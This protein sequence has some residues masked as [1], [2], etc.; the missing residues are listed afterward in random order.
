[1]ILF[2]VLI[3]SVV[4]FYNLYLKE[5]SRTEIKKQ[6]STNKAEDNANQMEDNANQEVNNLI[7]NLKYEKNSVYCVLYFILSYYNILKIYILIRW[8][9][10]HKTWN[11]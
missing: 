2:L 11:I 4:I 3:T 8:S 5:K 6:I 1:M 9:M 7:K 10:E